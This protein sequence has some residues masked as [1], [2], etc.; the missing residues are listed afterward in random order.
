MGQRFGS[1]T[2]LFAEKEGMISFLFYVQCCNTII[3]FDFLSNIFGRD[4][5]VIHL[6]IL[7]RHFYF[8]FVHS[9]KE[10]MNDTT[11]LIINI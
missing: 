9:Q 3:L 1:F 7:H 5:Y 10:Q 6:C 4:G 11:I 2:K 8:T